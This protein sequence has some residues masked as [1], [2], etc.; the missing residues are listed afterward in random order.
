MAGAAQQRDRRLVLLPAARGLAAPLVL[1]EVA[2]GGLVDAL[3]VLAFPPSRDPDADLDL[4]LGLHAQPRLVDRAAQPRCHVTRAFEVGLRH[5][6]RELV[7]TDA[8]AHVGSANDP[9]Q[10]LGD[11]L[12]RFAAAAV[13]QAVVDSL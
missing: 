7:S 3:P 10:L 1:I 2:V 5:R 9:L 4:L 11:Q 6:D 12:E 13:A 8:R